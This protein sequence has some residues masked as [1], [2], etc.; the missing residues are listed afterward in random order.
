MYSSRGRRASHASLERTVLPGHRQRILE[1]RPP[2]LAAS[3]GQ[4]PH[5]ALWSHQIP[6]GESRAVGQLHVVRHDPDALPELCGERQRIVHRKRSG[7]FPGCYAQHQLCL[8]I[9][10][11]LV[12]EAR[13]L[14]ER[15]RGVLRQHVHRGS[16]LRLRLAISVACPAMAADAH[17]PRFQQL[18]QNRRG[19]LRGLRHRQL[20]FAGRRVQRKCSGKVESLG[21]G[22]AFQ[23][24]HW[25]GSRR[26]CRR[27][28]AQS[29]DSRPGRCAIR[30]RRAY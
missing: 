22:I 23:A 14:R 30:E 25:L 11:Q 24:Q 26:C 29:V 18:H 27:V 21:I 10:A 3:P 13:I 8:Q 6:S 1:I 12:G 16:G 20:Q 15:R 2:G 17:A 9:H 28:V 5:H 19:V 4:Q 7:F